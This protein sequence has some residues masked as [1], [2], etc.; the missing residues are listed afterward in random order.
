MR[1]KILVTIA[2][3]GINQ[4]KELKKVLSEFNSF[5]KYEIRII[6]L[7]THKLNLGNYKKLKINQEIYPL[8]IKKNLPKQSLKYILKNKKK[9]DLFIYTENDMLLTEK[10]IDYFLEYSKKLKKTKFIP[11]FIRYELNSNKEVLLV[12]LYPEDI[13]NKYLFLKLIWKLFPR[14]FNKLQKRYQKKMI[15]GKIKE[16]KGIKYFEPQNMHQGSFVL[17]SKHLEILTKK[18]IKMKKYCGPL[19]TFASFPYHKNKFIK[20]I[21]IKDFEKSLIHHLPNKYLFS[22]ELISKNKFEEMLK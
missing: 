16:V 12:D 4:E 11:G 17:T 9:Y 22:R 6:L 21:P 20:I 14:V 5:Q 18:K 1:K 7:T 19:E 13:I 8:S 15:I 2:N 3:Y 10:T